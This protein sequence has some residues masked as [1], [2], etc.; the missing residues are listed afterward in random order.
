ML[1]LL[2]LLIHVLGNHHHHYLLVTGASTAV[3]PIATPQFRRKKNRTTVLPVQQRS[4]PS[5][6]TANPPPTAAWVNGFKNAIASAS[7]A[8]CCKTL[9]QPIDA[10][11][12]IQQYSTT[13]CS[14]I[15]AAKQLLSRPGGVKNLYAGLGVTVIGSMPSVGLYFGVYSYCKQRLIQ[16]PRFQF[17]PTACIAMSAAI[18]NTIASFSRVP[19]EVIKQQLQ[20]GQYD[21]TWTLFRTLMSQPKSTLASIYPKGGAWVQ[22]IRDVPYAVVTLLLYEHLQHQFRSYSFQTPPETTTSTTSS[23]K[24]R[25]FVLGGIAGGVGSWVTNPMD[26][27]K[28]RLQTDTL[29]QFHGSV[30]LCAAEI[31]R[32]GGAMAFLRGSIPRL[33]HKVPANAFFF[34]FF[35]VFKRILRVEEEKTFVVATTTTAKRTK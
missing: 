11:K 31:Y 6:A 30:R 7:A 10:I 35:E 21:S 32:E 29:A 1:L 4:L 3:V 19:Y 2:Q 5:T 25:D 15:E 26:V 14:V 9:L 16:S 34:W 22:I 8:A 24:T 18:G 27:I 23:S 20:T 28:T 33:V 13:R 12:T 17:Y